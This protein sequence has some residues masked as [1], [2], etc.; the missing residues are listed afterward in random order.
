MAVEHSFDGVEFDIWYLPE[1]LETKDNHQKLGSSDATLLIGHD[2]PKKIM[3]KNTPKFVE[4]LEHG[5]ALEYWM[6]LKNTT[7]EN[8]EIFAQKIFNLVKNKAIDLQKILIAPYITNYSLAQQ[9][10]ETFF[11]VFGKN[12]RFVCLCDSSN[13][14]APALDFIA[15][16]NLKFISID[17]HLL[18]KESIKELSGIEILAWTV[19][20]KSRFEAL[21]DLGVR[22]FATDDLTRAHL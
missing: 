7:A 12:L 16:N 9:V 14:I 21:T 6:D 19:N 22:Y 2:Y 13:Q 4:F 15:K 1:L 18:N 3:R 8:C 17:H 11:M 20:E 5:D 10:F